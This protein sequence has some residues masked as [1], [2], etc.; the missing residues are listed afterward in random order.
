[1]ISNL[2]TPL[3]RFL[4]ML[5]FKLWGEYP[6]PAAASVF[7][8]SHRFF[9]SDYKVIVFLRP[10]HLLSLPSCPRSLRRNLAQI[11][12]CVCIWTFNDRVYHLVPGNPGVHDVPRA[13]SL[14]GTKSLTWWNR[15]LLAVG[16]PHW[17]RRL[18]SVIAAVWSGEFSL[19]PSS[20]GA[21]V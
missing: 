1:M 6:L 9:L 17:P 13:N 7:V 19:G 21:S 5:I 11:W 2:A 10:S 12:L 18:C 3:V 16:T 4:W 8:N 20:N 15:V 14:L